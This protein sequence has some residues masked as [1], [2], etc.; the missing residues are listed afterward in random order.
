M[1]QECPFAV[2]LRED[3]VT[4]FTSEETKIENSSGSELS[5][6]HCLH[7]F[8]QHL[9]V[10]VSQNASEASLDGF[11]PE[12]SVTERRWEDRFRAVPGAHGFGA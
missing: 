1:I 6:H 11:T 12:N 4:Q 8:I 5:A 7:S 10:L 2:I 9:C 3:R